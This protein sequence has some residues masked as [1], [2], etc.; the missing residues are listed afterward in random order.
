VSSSNPAEVHDIM[1]RLDAACEDIGRDPAT[2]ARS[3]MA[4][5]LVGRD[6]EDLARRIAAQV[7]IFGGATDEAAAWLEERRDRWVLGGP[8]AAR[9][10]IAEF[11]ETGIDRLLFQ[12]FLPRDLE[13]VAIMAELAGLQPAG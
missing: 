1:G 3:A 2:L 4:G 11:A 6:E 7:A 12:D 5:V 8:E 10:R 9:A 13:H